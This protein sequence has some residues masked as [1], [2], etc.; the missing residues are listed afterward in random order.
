LAGATISPYV[1]LVMGLIVAHSRVIDD[2]Q[3]ELRREDFLKKLRQSLPYLGGACLL[4]LA[5]LGLYG[6]NSQ[7][8]EA[9]LVA[10]EAAYDA[11]VADMDRGQLG[12]A[13]EAFARLADKRSPLWSLARLR[14]AECVL[15]QMAGNAKSGQE[16][17]P[18]GVQ[19]LVAQ[20][21][22]AVKQDALNKGLTGADSPEQAASGQQSDAKGAPRAEKS[23]RGQLKAAHDHIALQIK[24]APL[25]TFLMFARAFATLD[26]PDSRLKSKIGGL[27][28]KSSSWYSLALGWQA[29][30]FYRQGAAPDFVRRHMTLWAQEAK[31]LGDSA[32]GGLH[33][34]SRYCRMGAA[35]DPLP[36]VSNSPAVDLHHKD[37]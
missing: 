8:K 27:L 28:T 25:E 36:K 7:R 6:W 5:G 15:G 32:P 24:S 22:Q 1:V 14:Q 9:Q 4:I 21:N 20:P 18:E 37:L 13:K 12:L 19:G 11:A 30:G 33:W 16:S 34:I 3:E 17:G 23:L 35:L 29:L 10:D 2:I 26:H 31:S